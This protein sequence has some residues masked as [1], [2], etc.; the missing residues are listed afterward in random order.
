MIRWF[1]VRPRRLIG[2]EAKRNAIGMS[3]LWSYLSSV[4]VAWH[5]NDDKAHAHRSVQTHHAAPD[6]SSVSSILISFGSLS[7]ERQWFQV[8]R[9]GIAGKEDRNVL[10]TPLFS[11]NV[12]VLLLM[13]QPASCTSYYPKLKV[14]SH[15]SCTMEKRI[16]KTINVD[17]ADVFFCQ[18]AS[19]EKK[20]SVPQRASRQMHRQ[21]TTSIRFFFFSCRTSPSC[22][23]SRQQEKDVV[24]VGLYDQKGSKLRKSCA[25][26]GK[27]LIAIIFYPIS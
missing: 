15:A 1:F 11:N 6:V 7:S 10:A 3:L 12:V 27:K 16:S 4:T 14:E 20:I 21:T 8:F 22:A 23:S 5:Q 17:A 13:Q 19:S 24:A 2:I 9:V 18:R 25:S 26:C